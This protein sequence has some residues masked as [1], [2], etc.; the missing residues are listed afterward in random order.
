MTDPLADGFDA[1]D[2]ETW[3]AK[4]AGEEA[5]ALPAT[6]LGEGLEA[7][8]LYT[9]ADA[10]APDPG[11]APGRAPYVRGARGAGAWEIRQ[12]HWPPERGAARA[13]I[14]E[15]LEGGTTAIGL[16]LDRAARDGDAPG[17]EAFAAGRGAD[18]VAISTLDDLDAVLDGVYLDLAPVALRG[19]AQALP[20]A[21]LLTALWRRRGHDLATVRGSFGVD[22]LGTLA[23]EGMLSAAPGEALAQAGELAAETAAA[24]PRVAALALD[25]RPYAEAGAG[26]ALELAVALSGGVALLRACEQAGLPPAAAAPRIEFTLQVGADQFL[27]LAKLRAWRRLW[28]RVL[29]RCGV[30]PAG[31]RSPTFARTSER[32]MAAVDPWVNMLRAATATFA[33]AI[34]GAD[35]ISVAPF[36]VALGGVASPLGRRIAR[37]TQL[38]LLEEAALARVADPGGGAWYV[39]SLTDALAAA[40][41]ERFQELEGDGG[42][43]EAL[44]SGALAAALEQSAAAERDEIA[45]RARKLTGVNVFPLLGDERIE[46]PEPPDLAAL[47][48]LDA[49]RL[50]EHGDQRD[51]ARPEPGSLRAAGPGGRLS[52]AALLAADGARIDELAAALAGAERWTALPLA[53]VRPSAP[54]ERLRALAAAHEAATGAPPRVLLACLGPIARHNVTATWARSFFE[55]GGVAAVQSEPLD[56][57]APDAAAAALRTAGAPLAAICADREQEPAAIAAAVAALRAAGARAVYLPLASAE[58]A[59][60]AEGA[61]VALR[62]GVDMVDLLARALTL[63]GVAGAAEAAR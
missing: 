51:R 63:A 61:A 54:F 21:A 15:D 57:A 44:A 58:Q 4:A 8:W 47:A 41:W 50:A 52:A 49:A 24:L 32:T 20:A 43:L 53:P 36:D 56:P 5:T 35:G 62:D 27:E 22:P 39:E 17:S 9:S 7:R 13:A 34:G 14:L 38:V 42:V 33:A 29:E 40:A 26:A 6:A 59:S 10:L 2:L 1:V 28:A 25:T 60:A 11:G 45:R 46:R 30:E 48:R 37:N 31:R 18:G 12:E 55:S 3:L 19:G 23:G 16:R